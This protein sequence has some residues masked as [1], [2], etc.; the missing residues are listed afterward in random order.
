VLAHLEKLEAD[1]LVSTTPN[2]TISLMAVE[3]RPIR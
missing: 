1:G 3:E 2:G